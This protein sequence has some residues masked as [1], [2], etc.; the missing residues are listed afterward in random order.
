MKHEIISTTDFFK[1]KAVN[2]RT[3]HTEEYAIISGLAEGEA[4]KFQYD[5]QKEAISV[6]GAIARKFER[7]KN[8]RYSV[9]RRGNIVYVGKVK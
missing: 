2:G 4:V 8:D 6:Y 3:K 5:T 9:C 1:D 7:T